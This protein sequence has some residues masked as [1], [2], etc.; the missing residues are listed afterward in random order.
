MSKGGVYCKDCGVKERGSTIQL[1]KW[2]LVVLA[3]L[4]ILGGLMLSAP[5]TNKVASY[6]LQPDSP[7]IQPTLVTQT[8]QPSLGCSGSSKSYCEDKTLNYDPDCRSSNWVFK[9]KFCPYGCENGV[10][11]ERTCPSTCEDNN[12]CTSDYCS[13]MTSFECRHDSLNGAQPGC[14]GVAGTCLQY[15]C[16]SGNCISQ[17]V[18]PCCG[19]NICEQTE[20]YTTCLTDCPAPKPKL[21][22]EIKGCTYRY[23]VWTLSDI[24]TM[25]ISITNTGNGDANEVLLVSYNGTGGSVS[26]VF[27]G[28]IQA[29]YGRLVT[30]EEKKHSPLLVKATGVDPITPTNNIAT[31]A[32]IQSCNT[33]DDS[34]AK[35]L[36]NVV[37]YGAETISKF[38][39]KIQIG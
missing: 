36:Q 24:A 3:V 34:Q 38:V 5:S 20:S 32:G 17:G 26:Q 15:T 30:M 16:S 12:P 21:S 6:N 14:L 2:H 1:K 28:T 25:Y 11:L 37:D 19:N 18:Q 22:I 8:V 9:Q 10:C 31:Q 4:L 13:E 39:P 35:I 29:G 23:D 33:L 7:Y 27:A